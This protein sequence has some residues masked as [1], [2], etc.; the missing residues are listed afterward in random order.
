MNKWKSFYF[1][2]TD[3]YRINKKEEEE[4]EEEGEQIIQLLET[5]GSIW[6]CKRKSTKCI[7][8]C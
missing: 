5:S 6:T 2:F 3:K 4:E 1:L 8:W 7:R